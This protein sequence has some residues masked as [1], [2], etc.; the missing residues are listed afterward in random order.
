MAQE[1]I[2]F[3]GIALRF[4]AALALVLLTFNP[5][6]WSYF[7]WLYKSVPGV[8]PP[9]VLAGIA[10]LIAW[11]IF[12]GATM[13]SIGIA[14]VVLFGAFFG[15]L[16]WTAVFYGWLSLE[17]TGAMVWVG[18]LVLASVLAMGMSW[19]HLRRQMSGQADVDEVS[20]K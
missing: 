8:T 19:S 15:A 5:S 1:S 4:A 17:N 12:V 20:S 3:S 2:G 14:G 10:L 18:L 9:L 16:V 6:G 11:A 7:H 13:R